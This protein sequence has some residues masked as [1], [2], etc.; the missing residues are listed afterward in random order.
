MKFID[1]V[2]TLPVG[3]HFLNV[4]ARFAQRDNAAGTGPAWS[5]YKAVWLR[6]EVFPP[7]NKKNASKF[8]VTVED[9]NWAEY[10]DRNFE[11]SCNMFL[12]EEHRMQ[13]K[14]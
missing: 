4:T 6:V 2:R 7:S 9:L 1:Y 11:E 8:M 3:V 10:T 5:K 13:L 12:A 14:E